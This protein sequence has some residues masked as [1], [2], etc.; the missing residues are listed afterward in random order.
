MRRAVESRLTTWQRSP[1]RK[2]LIVRGAR[3]VGKT[4]SISRFGREE[5]DDFFA[6]DFERAKR[7]HSV[8]RGDLDP[9]RILAELEVEA[10]RRI[11]PGT[12]LVL[13]DEI[14]ACP[15]A[16]ASLRYFYEELPGLHLI[17][18]GSLLELALGD[19]SFPM[20]RVQFEWMR[21]LSFSEFLDGTGFELLRERIPSLEG[22]I[23]ISEAIHAGLLEQ[24][25]RYFI[26]GG[27]PEAVSRYAETGSFKEVAEVHYAL[28]LALQQ[29]FV[30]YNKRAN[31]TVLESLLEQLPRQVG[32]QI[33]YRHLDPDRHTETVKSALRILERALI[34]TRVQ[35]STAQGLPLGAGTR[36]KVFKSVFLDIGLMQH[37]SGINIA[38]ILHEDDLLKVYRGALA[39]QFVG[40]EMLANGAGSENDKLYY[41]ARARR[42][43]NAEIDYLLAHHGH[44]HPIEVKSGPRGRL[45]SLA[46]FL[47]EHPSA[48]HGLVLSPAV[49][50]RS[51]QDNMMF[52]PIYTNLS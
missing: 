20:G 17:A 39:E 3:Q 51:L 48:A 26:V 28:A 14:Q 10:G 32:C 24:L 29:S 40:Q 46:L 34:V 1:T 5:Y 7:L 43:S 13:F 6:F 25:R 45:R 31:I 21:P 42:G 37:L 15:A 49:R 23:D 35:S 16:I 41:W 19:I 22:G 27:M 47:D 50:K 11:V 38:T 9:R 4:Y 36:P 2:P 12:A 30:K 52:L 8:F 33:S 44:I 18:A